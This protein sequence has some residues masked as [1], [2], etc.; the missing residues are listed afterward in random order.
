MPNLKASGHFCL[1][2]TALALAG[3]GASPD[4]GARTP[5]G[6]ESGTRTAA[7]AADGTNVAAC[8]DGN[9]EILVSG[10]VDIDLHDH[11]GL[12]RLS[13]V[14]VDPSGLGFTTTSPGGTGSGE[15]QGGCTLTFYEGGQGSSCGGDQ[16][17]PQKQTGVLAMQLGDTADDGVVLRLVSGEPGPPPSWLAPPRIR[18]PIITP[19]KIP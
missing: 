2:L 7:T 11:G 14:R 18:P 10:P 8:A 13:V 15:I 4:G 12:T 3:C 17:P 9:C 16:A 6:D 19:P 5:S 1:L